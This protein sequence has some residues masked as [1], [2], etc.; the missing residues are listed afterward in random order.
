MAAVGAATRE[1]AVVLQFE[2]RAAEFADAFVSAIHGLGRRDIACLHQVAV[3]GDGA[4]QIFVMRAG[5][6]LLADDGNHAVVVPAVAIAVLVRDRLDLAG[7]RRDFDLVA[8]GA[9]EVANHVVAE[10][11]D[12]VIVGSVV[13]TGHANPVDRAVGIDV[14]GNDLVLGVHHHFETEG[15]CAA[16]AGQRIVDGLERSGFL[17]EDLRL[18][19]LGCDH[20]A[21]VRPAEQDVV[22]GAA[23]HPVGAEAADNKVG[24]GA[25]G[26]VV[27][28]RAAPKLVS[29]GATVEHVVAGHAGQRV[30]LG[31]RRTRRCCPSSRSDDHGRSCRRRTWRKN[32]RSGYC[33]GS[34]SD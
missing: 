6:A 33:R 1:H 14:L 31:A 25:A 18:A 28:P 2:V 21:S 32:P 5:I 9:I 12:P 29:A 16:A 30:F 8:L 7:V 19:V 26:E 20:F 24:A 3:D 10:A 13:L 22:A 27:I 15:V 4:E 23:V 11:V 17:R 34:R